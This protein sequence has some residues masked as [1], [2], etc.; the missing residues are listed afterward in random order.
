MSPCKDSTT[1]GREPKV[2]GSG[3]G[4][5]SGRVMGAVERCDH[6]A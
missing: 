2:Y 5:I 1:A 3:L 6:V 4:E